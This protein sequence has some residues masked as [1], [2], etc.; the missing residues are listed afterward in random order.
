VV[1]IPAGEAQRPSTRP[2]PSRS[3]QSGPPLD[4]AKHAAAPAAGAPGPTAPGSLKPSTR[5]PG[6][7]API[8]PRGPL[9]AALVTARPRQ[10][11]KNLL[12]I[13]APGA[14]GAL[15]R[16]GV[17]ARVTL[18][19]VAFCL[20]ASGI[21]AINDVRDAAEDRLHPRKRRRPIAAG[22]LSPRAG[23][24]LGG[25][26]ML[27]GL[28][29]CAWLGGLL[30]LIGAGYVLLT[31]S[32]TLLWRHVI[33]LDV[34]AIAGGF[35]LRA[36]AGGAAAPVALSKWFLLVISCAAVLV[37]AG[38]RWAELRRTTLAG[39]SRRRVLERY[40]E[41]RL[42]WLLGLAGLGALVAYTIWASELPSVHGIPWRP[43]TIVPFALCLT[44]YGLLVRRGQGETPEELILGDRPLLAGAVAW[45]VLFALGVHAA[46]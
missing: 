21:Y 5:A 23:V 33:V 34:L 15:G 1:Q 46:A 8:P 24:W 10:W 25:V 9:L 37:A 22:Q 30:L 32:Y 3:A 11:I 40:S 16:D 18:A 2:A 6:P 29:M 28:A 12:V 31:L 7:P 19:F 35:V 20:I 27:A 14:A 42:R 4:P 36:V 17:P 41:R 13:A 39:T 44:R 38:K 43:L 45:L 26:W